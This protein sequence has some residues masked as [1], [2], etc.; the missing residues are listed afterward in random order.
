QSVFTHLAASEDPSQDDF[1]LQQKEKFE[2]AAE[3]LGKLIGY[4][5]LKHIANSAAIS[6]LP[7]F[8]MD[9][10]RLGIGMYGSDASGK[11]ELHPVAT[12]R[13]T[14][15]QIKHVRAGESVSY[16]RKGIVKNDSIIATVRIGYADG[17]PRRL[18]NGIGK[19]L[20][21]GKLAP[22]IGAVCMDMTMLDVTSIAGVVEGDEVIVFGKELSIETIA[23]SAQ[24]IPYEIMTGISQRV[25]RIYY[26]E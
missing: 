17:Y 18:G 14:V 23:D 12:L 24:T 4:K 11:M 2:K 19:M 10:V 21:K 22:V 13:S 20:V 5:F 15:A 26:Q 1:T 7:Q 25:K 3:E 6:R 8:Q 9:M 16:N